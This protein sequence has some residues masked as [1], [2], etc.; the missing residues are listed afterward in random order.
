MNEHSANTDLLIR[1]LDG[2]L[3]G[4]ELQFIKNIL[5]SN[6][7][8]LEELENLRLAREAVGSYGLRKKIQAIHLE[9]MQEL[10]QKT[11]P[12]TGVTRMIFQYSFRVAAVLIILFGISTLYQYYTGTPE[13]LFSD[14]FQ[15]FELR[16]LRGASGNH[17]DE[18]YKAGNMGAV[19]T[20]FNSL[21]NPLAEDYFLAGNAFL[22]SRQPNKAIEAFI[23]LQQINKSSN[24]HLFEDDTEYYLALAYLDNGQV[25]QALPIME[26][27]HA[28]QNHPYNR[29]VGN[30]FILKLK[31]L[32]AH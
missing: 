1:Y 5:A 16:E 19:I 22:S 2:E 3:E 25:A 14:K 7:E 21:S 29:Q 23:D 10:K 6:P 30:W 24:Q 15:A 8:L 11:S 18:Q 20:K 17:L 4:E 9:M 31:R 28:D 32:N 26:K 13:K 27:I 12:R